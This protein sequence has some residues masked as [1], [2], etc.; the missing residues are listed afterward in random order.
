MEKTTAVFPQP[1][2]IPANKKMTLP[3]LS[4]RHE[5]RRRWASLNNMTP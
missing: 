2:T 4:H 3:N 1:D 5:T